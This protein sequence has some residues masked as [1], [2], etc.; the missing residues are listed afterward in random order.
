MLKTYFWYIRNHSTQQH[1]HCHIDQ[2][3]GH[4]QYCLYSVENI[5][6]YNRHRIIH[7]CILLVKFKWYDWLQLHLLEAW[8]SQVHNAHC[9]TQMLLHV[10]NEF[11]CVTGSSPPSSLTGNTSTILYV[12]CVVFTVGRTW[13]VAVTTVNVGSNT[14]FNDKVQWKKSS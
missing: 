11:T 7:R 13:F 1:S 4:K 12:T 2:S 6:V 10:R 8:T 3:R 5:L 9:I 14:T